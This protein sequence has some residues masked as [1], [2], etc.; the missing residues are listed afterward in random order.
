MTVWPSW[1][2]FEYLQ[3]ELLKRITQT[4]NVLYKCKENVK[5][6]LEENEVLGK[7]VKQYVEEVM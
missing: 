6:D 1:N 5:V 7:T 2:S 3:I 4:L